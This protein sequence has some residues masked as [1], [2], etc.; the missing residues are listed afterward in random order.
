MSVEDEAPP[1]EAVS[2]GSLSGRMA[3]RVQTLEKQQTEWFPIPG[4]E[5][6]LEVE[7]RALGYKTIRAIQTRNEKIREP[8]AREL[9]NMADQLVTATQ[10]VREVDGDEMRPI[11]D[12]WIELA[13]RLPKCPEQITQRQAVIFLVTDK[14]IH[15]LVSD[16]GRWASTVRD[17]IDEEVVRDFDRTG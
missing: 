11:S 9:A 16:W 4:Y 5:G 3:Q 15:F 13:Q 17:D 14:R 12:G 8:T 10:A 7:L 2:S 1:I 6:I